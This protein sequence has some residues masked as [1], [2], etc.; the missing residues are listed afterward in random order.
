MAISAPNIHHSMGKGGL[1]ESSGDPAGP[2]GLPE[3]VLGCQLASLLGG[4]SPSPCSVSFLARLTPS[5]AQCATTKGCSTTAGNARASPEWAN[6]TPQ[7]PQAR[8]LAADSASLARDAPLKTQVFLPVH[9]QQGK[10]SETLPLLSV[11]SFLSDKLM[12]SDAP[13]GICRGREQKPR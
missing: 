12:A 8:G 7:H 4:R 11:V 13:S 9:Q 1:Q 10:R 3:H 2:R 6:T 5:S